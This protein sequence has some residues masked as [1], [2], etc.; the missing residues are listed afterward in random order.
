MCRKCLLG[1]PKSP[2][3]KSHLKYGKDGSNNFVFTWGYFFAAA[4][5]VST[6]LFD[7]IEAEFG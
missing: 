2:K 5:T 3:N 6:D 4:E 7:L 1:R